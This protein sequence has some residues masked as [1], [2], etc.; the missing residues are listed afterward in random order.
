[1]HSECGEEVE[2]FEGGL[3]P[4]ASWI[5]WNK[6]R[7]KKEEIDILDILEGIPH[8][9]IDKAVV[10]IWQDDPLNLPW[11]IWGYQKKI[12]RLKLGQKTYKIPYIYY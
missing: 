3:T 7:E 5:W 6:L 8:P 1:M 11:M 2:N 12:K 9:D 4:T 10:Y